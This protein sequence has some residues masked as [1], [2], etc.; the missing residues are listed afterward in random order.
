MFD[1]CEKLTNIKLNNYH[2]Y[3][4]DYA[5]ANC[6][7]LAKIT[8]PPNIYMISEHMFDGCTNLTQI[9]F[10]SG[11]Q[12]RQI[13]DYAFANCP[14][15]TSITLPPSVNDLQ[16]LDSQWLAGSSIDRVVFQGLADEVFVKEVK[17]IKE[18]TY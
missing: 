11:S 13:G 2:S 17:T 10:E 12:L 5:F 6:K 15:L 4:G 8:F 1:G 18:I 9:A 16:Y 14:K 3:V 7:S